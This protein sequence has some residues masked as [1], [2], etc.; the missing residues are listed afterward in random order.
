MWID[1][2]LTAIDQ[3]NSQLDSIRKIEQ[4]RQEKK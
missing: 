1:P 4:T 3:A 2:L